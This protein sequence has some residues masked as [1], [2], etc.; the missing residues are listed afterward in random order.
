[1][2]KTPLHMGLELPTLQ[3]IKQFVAMGHGVALLPEI[4]VE[5]ELASGELVAIPV[6]ELQLTRKLRLI[7]RKEANLSHAGTA[8]LKVAEAVAH[9]RKG[10]Y[11]FQRES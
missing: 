2:H 11:R 5:T 4:S 8:L 7:Y 10:R 1:M 9:E 3:A 6:K